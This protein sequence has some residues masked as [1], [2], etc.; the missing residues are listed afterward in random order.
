MGND[1]MKAVNYVG[2]HQV[3]VEEVEKPQLEHPDDIIVKVT[4]VS[5]VSVNLDY[6]QKLTRRIGCHL[7]FRPPVR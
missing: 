3:K 4:T 6:Q 7:W 5:T 2:P 1:K